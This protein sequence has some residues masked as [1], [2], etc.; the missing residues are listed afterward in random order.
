MLAN[1]L[2]DTLG[3][4]DAVDG[5]TKS[6]N[7]SGL[8]QGVGGPADAYR[9]LLIAG[10]LRRRFGPSIGASLAS[11]YELLN[12]LEGQSGLNR[13]MDDLNNDIALDGPDFRTFED[14]QRWARGKIS[15]AAPFNGDGQDGR[16]M[17]HRKTARGWQPDWSNVP[18]LSIE[19]GGAEH[20]SGLQLR[21]GGS[22]D[23]AADDP[24]DRVVAA[25]SKQDVA[26]I[27]R[28]EAYRQSSHPDHAQAQA[29]VRAWFERHHGGAGAR[30]ATR[31]MPQQAAERARSA[32][33]EVHVR[34]H[35][36]EGGQEHVR[37]HTRSWPA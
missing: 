13:H 33:R 35:M 20:H 31:R 17:W 36:R 7:E 4:R 22:G 18:L 28:S 25:W 12:R 14:V 32:G 26:T 9:H 8:P 5:A 19:R 11:A 16:V 24:L 10:E 37:A 21:S 29:L 34:A 6:A 2:I 23:M 30:G 1:R 15:E 27:M 3:V